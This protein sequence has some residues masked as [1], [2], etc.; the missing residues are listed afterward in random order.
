MTVG[1]DEVRQPQHIWLP[2]VGQACPWSRP[3]RLLG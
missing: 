2:K 3:E 1:S